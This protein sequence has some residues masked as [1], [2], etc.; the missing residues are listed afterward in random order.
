M[1]MTGQVV[2]NDLS[3]TRVLVLKNGEVFQGQIQRVENGY[4]VKQSPRSELQIPLRDVRF[5]CKSL[6]EAYRQM[7]AA[8]GVSNL[9][10]QLSLAEWCLEQG[11]HNRAA[12]HWMLSAATSPDHP[13]V[14]SLE[15]RLKA[16]RH[17]ASNVNDGDKYQVDLQT[18]TPSASEDPLPE[19]VTQRTVLLPFT[20]LVQP[21]L[22]NHC[23]AGACHGGQSISRFRLYRLNGKGRMTQQFTYQNLRS[24]LKQ[25]DLADPHRSPL[26]KSDELLKSDRNSSVT[27]IECARAIWRQKFPDQYSKIVSWILQ[28]SGQLRTDKLGGERSIQPD[29]PRPQIVPQNP[30]DLATDQNLAT[31]PPELPQNDFNRYNKSDPFDPEIYNRRYFARRTEPLDEPPFRP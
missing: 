5:V 18:K 13:K 4:L 29:V 21:V 27:T 28:T 23:A 11:L 6:G 9:R 8:V 24:V 14:E 22:I 2:A 25:I 10:Q 17:S 15:R 1:L 7:T 16:A 26:L 12:H 3:P 20:L 19:V 31:G 30:T